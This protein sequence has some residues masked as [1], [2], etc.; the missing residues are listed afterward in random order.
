MIRMFWSA[1]S[2]NGNISKWN[3]SRVTNMDGL[4]SFLATSFDNHISEW[5]VSRVTNMDQMFMSAALFKHQ[6]Y[7]WGCLGQFKSKNLIF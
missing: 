6:L 2:F 1:T 7:L 4:F 3:V 5:N